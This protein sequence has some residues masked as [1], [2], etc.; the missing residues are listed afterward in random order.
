MATVV[1]NS[2]GK[3]DN[4]T[5]GGGNNGGNSSGNPFV[6]TWEGTMVNG[7]CTESFI[8][9]FTADKTCSQKI[10]RTCTDPADNKSSESLF[11]YSYSENEKVISFM[12]NG[13]VETWWKY[14][15]S[16]NTLVLT[17]GE[18]EKGTITLTKQ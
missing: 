12:K 3:D 18:G 13:R 4:K 6:G 14:S 8:G 9:T 11:T 2:C 16:G 15:F 17:D 10:E 1:F 5:A 7:D